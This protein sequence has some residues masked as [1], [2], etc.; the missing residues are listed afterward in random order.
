MCDYWNMALSQNY[1]KH[2]VA[3]AQESI[4]VIIIAYH[5]YLEFCGISG[6]QKWC[7]PATFVLC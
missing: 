5:I 2:L 3:V 6:N 7:V 1:K 4:T